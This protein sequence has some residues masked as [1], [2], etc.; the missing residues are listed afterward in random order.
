[1][2][3]FEFDRAVS[4]TGTPAAVWELITDVPRLVGWIDVVHDAREIEPLSHYSAVIQDKVGMFRLRADLD[5][6]MTE[7][8]EGK[9]IVAH[10]E[11]QDRQVGSRITI[12]AEVLLDP[13]PSST[14]VRVSGKYGITG[15]VATLGSSAIK[16]K[17]DKVLKEFFGHLSSD[18][19]GA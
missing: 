6:H 3:E 10:A 8:D 2:A 5:I 17:G 19:S 15:N 13:A 4:V 16:R 9:R 11:G 18:S 12:D 14:S 1:M 7:V